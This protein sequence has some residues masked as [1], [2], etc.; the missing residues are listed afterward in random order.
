MQ[1]TKATAFAIRTPPPNFGG[2]Y[3][4]FVKLETD[5]GLVG[6]GE[7]AVLF[8]MYG[9]ERAF[10]RLVDGAFVI[11]TWVGLKLLVEYAHTEGWVHF[12]I[13]KWLSLGLIVVI[14]GISYWLARRQGPVE[15][16]EPSGA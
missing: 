13:P 11:I 9:M 10:E 2:Y 15:D 4:Y 16:E 1:L 6:W 12:E 7:T 5:S 14:F 3:W 8:S